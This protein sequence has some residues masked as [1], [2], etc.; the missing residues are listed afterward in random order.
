M[1]GTIE[2]VYKILADMQGQIKQ[3]REKVENQENENKQLT[4]KVENQQIEIEALK[5]Q[6]NLVVPENKPAFWR[7]LNS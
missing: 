3:L 7:G 4:E 5:A 6:K 2:D 1:F